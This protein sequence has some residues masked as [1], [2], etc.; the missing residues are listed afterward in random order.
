MEEPGVPR[1]RS[2]ESARPAE[3]SVP[4]RE[5][6]LRP[7]RGRAGQRE[8][9]Q[10]HP[11]PQGSEQLPPPGAREAGGGAERGGALS[12]FRPLTTSAREIRMKGARAPEGTHA[13]TARQEPAWSPP[14]GRPPWSSRPG[15]S[16]GSSGGLPDAGRGAERNPSGRGASGGGGAG[17]PGTGLRTRCWSGGRGGAGPR[18]RPRPAPARGV[19]L[20]AQPARLG[21]AL[22]AFRTGRDAGRP[23]HGGG[24]GHRLP[25]PAGRHRGLDGAGL[26]PAQAATVHREKGGGEGPQT[27]QEVR[28]SDAEIQRTADKVYRMIEERLRRERRRLGF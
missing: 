25:A 14:S 20:P 11:A 12:A 8:P 13:L 4:G 10:E 1:I 6:A 26:P 24:P 19:G 18:R 3:Q 5:A 7:P 16:R 22:F 2:G 23:E 15:R 9:G 17:A 27:R 28:V 21:A